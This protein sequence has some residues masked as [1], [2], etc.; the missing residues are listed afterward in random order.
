MT[1]PQSLIDGK[2]FWLICLKLTSADIYYVYVSC[3]R[4]PPWFWFE[5]RYLNAGW[6]YLSAF[7]EHLF[8]LF[9]RFHVH[10]YTP[11][12]EELPVYGHLCP[13]VSGLRAWPD[14]G[15][16]A[17]TL[18]PGGVGGW[19]GR[20]CGAPRSGPCWWVLC[21]TWWWERLFSA[22][23]SPPE[24]TLRTK[25]YLKPNKTSSVTTPVSLTWTSTSLSRYH[26]TH[27]PKSFYIIHSNWT[28]F[29]LHINRE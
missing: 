2:M 28:D 12:W 16:Q 29:A 5:H 24:R 14:P 4:Q 20:T 8:C 23:W 3:Q 22:P 25:P 6:S 10:S 15:L 13:S 11:S 1:N 18:N 17:L 26:R 9:S 7:Q 21:C 19:T 27:K